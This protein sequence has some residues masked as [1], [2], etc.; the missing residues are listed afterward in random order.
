MSESSGL[1]AVDRAR[2]RQ[3]AIVPVVLAILSTIGQI[4]S[5][6]LA[7]EAPLLLIA[8]TPLDPFL[9]LTVNSVPTWAFFTVG[10]L[11]LVAAD[12]FLYVIG[13]DYGPRGRQL[14]VDEL[15]ASSR[16]ARSIIWLDRWFPR[17]G[18]A[19]IVVL[20]NYPVCL[21]AGFFRVQVWRFAL[22]NA[23]GTAGRLYLIWSLGRVFSGPIGSFVE[24]I[25]RY[26]LI[27]AVVMGAIVA[28]QVS[29]N[30]NRDS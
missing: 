3:L 29:T 25:G 10:F 23:I 18:L 28:T 7:N 19:L 12:G 24:F 30:R 11:R 15:G 22:L 21:M 13:R 14:L 4:P 16:I 6:T 27:A 5:A 17:L 26:Q 2:L 9:I 8:M 1:S 20:P